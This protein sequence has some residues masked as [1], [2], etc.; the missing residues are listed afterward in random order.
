MSRAARRR[1]VETQPVD[2]VIVLGAAMA[3]PGVPGPALKRRLAHGVDVFRRRHARHLVLS[4]GIVGP[5][6]AE[7]VAMRALALAMGVPETAIVV[8]DRARNTFEN[9]VFCGTIIRR[10]AWRRV[11]V[12]TDGFHLARAL[13]V[14]R[15]IGLDVE[16]EAVARRPP[17]SRWWWLRQHADERARLA[18]SAWLFARGAHKPL[19]ATEWGGEEHAHD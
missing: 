3:A 5:P 1:G 11:I 19:L 18:Y 10:R 6:P 13:F 12:V 14:F 15:R 4:G 9:A 7:A 8:E 16:G 2:A 17:I